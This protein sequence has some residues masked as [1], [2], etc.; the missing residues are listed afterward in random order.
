MTILDN[1]IEE[2]LQQAVP[3]DHIVQNMLHALSKEKPPHFEI[4]AKKYTFQTGQ[5]GILYNYQ[6]K[7]VTISFIVADSVYTDMNVSFQTFKVILEGL[8]ICIRQ[9]KW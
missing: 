5:H 8:A 6:T 4:P 3:K 1:F 9:Q 7:T 2:T